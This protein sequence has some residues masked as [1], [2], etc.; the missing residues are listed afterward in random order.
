[1][2]KHYYDNL[3]QLKDN[4]S[5]QPVPLEISLALPEDYFSATYQELE[6]LL[7]EVGVHGSHTFSLQYY[8]QLVDDLVANQRGT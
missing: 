1:M 2:I 5:V 7:R 6:V 3:Q 4:L 8:Y